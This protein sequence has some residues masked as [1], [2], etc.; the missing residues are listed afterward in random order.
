LNLD[1]DLASLQEVRNLLHAATKAQKIYGQFSQEKINEVCQ[2]IADAGVANSER[3]AKMAQ[4]ETGFGIWQD[5]VI[6]NIFASKTV[7]DRY[8]DMKTVGIVGEHPEKKTIDIA[9]PVGVVAGIIPSTN[10]TSSIFYKSLVALKGGNAIVFSPH[11]GAKN[12]ILEA[13]KVVQ[14]AAYK[15]GAPEG[16]IG[17]ITHPTIEASQELMSHPD[18]KYIIATGGGLMVHAAYSSGTPA[19]GVGP[20]NGSAFIEKSANVAQAVKRIMDSETFDNGTICASEQSI[21]AENANSEEVRR[22]LKRQGAYFLNENESAALSKFMLRSDG[23]M[24]PQIVGKSVQQLADLALITVPQDTRVLVVPDKAE[25]VGKKD[26][27]SREK[28]TPILAYFEVENCEAAAALTVKLL[29]NE[30]IGHTAIIHSENMDT[31]RKYALLVPAS[32]ILVNVAGA[33][34]G[35]GAATNLNPALTLGCGAV[36]GSATSENISPLDLIN[37]KHVAVGVTELDDIKREATNV[38][39]TGG[40]KTQVNF[41]QKQLVDELVRQVL[42]KIQ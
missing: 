1:Q 34:G 19:I 25:N 12:C 35:I 30:G 9:V 32:R 13:V 2:A 8:K 20:G 26:P 6:K 38:T 15:A 18:T 7:N 17:T 40:N 24:N 10:P 27:F 11:P 3:L 37:M 42:Q 21:I 4:Q 14:D 16:L 22:E 31:V 29:E 33:L 36:G 23:T 41:D 39:A 5:K 28:L